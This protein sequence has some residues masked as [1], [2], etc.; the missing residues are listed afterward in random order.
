LVVVT[1]CYADSAKEELEQTDGIDYVVNNARKSQ[2]FSLVDGHF[3]G[4]VQD[5]QK[6]EQDWFSYSLPEEAFHT[7]AMVKIQDG[8]DNFCTFCIIP[9][10]RG[11]AKKPSSG[12]NPG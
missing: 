7:R 8:C 6:L 4:E 9:Y 11:R 2:V 1:G 12:G 3:K 10:V 5:S